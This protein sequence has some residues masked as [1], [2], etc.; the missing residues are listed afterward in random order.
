MTN[1]INHCS[2][3]CTVDGAG[4]SSISKAVVQIRIGKPPGA[5]SRY[6]WLLPLSLACS[7]LWCQSAGALTLGWDTSPSPNVTGYR[8]WVSIGTASFVPTLTTTNLSVTVQPSATE[9]TRYFATSLAGLLESPPSA[10]VTNLIV[11]VPPP[12]PTRPSPPTDLSYTLPAGNRAD[13]TWKTASTNVTRIEK[14]LIGQPFVQVTAVGPGVT[15]WTTT[16]KNNQR[17]LFRLR[18]CSAGLC[19]DYS[20][21]LQVSR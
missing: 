8:L 12:I 15:H 3:C 10:V 17:A 19:S 21:V 6:R 11:T 9:T 18:A 13:I 1:A 7:F 4:T 2:P 20:A 16:L 14:A 5:R